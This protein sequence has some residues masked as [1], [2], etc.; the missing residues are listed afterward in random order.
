MGFTG[1]SLALAGLLLAGMLAALESG[2]RLGLRRLAKHPDGAKAGLGAVEGAVFGL[3][4]LVVAFTFSGAASR[5]DSRRQLIAQEANAIGTA[6]LRL[7]F[8]AADDQRP[9]QVAFRGYLDARLAQTQAEP[10]STA[11]ASAE[12]EALRLQGVIWEQ[13]VAAVPR[14][15]L[16]S[17]PMLVV[18][19]IN[20]MIDLTTTRSMAARLHPPGVVYLMLFVL[21]F[22]GALMAG[23]GTA[24]NRVRSWLHEL[25]FAAIFAVTVFVIIDLE[26]PRRGLIRIH[27]ADQ[28]LLD[29]RAQMK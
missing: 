7:D 15:P 1:E 11:A 17:A 3:L 5:F 25:G 28:V 18:P 9:L 24:E 22:A 8:L 29:L 19:P 6:Y 20:E 2:R 16:P 10:G 14:A 12:R 13:A 27:A 23:F 26:Y 4:G 21:A